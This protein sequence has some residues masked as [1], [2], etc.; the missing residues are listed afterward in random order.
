MTARRSKPPRAAGSLLL[1]AA[2]WGCGG[3]AGASANEA[4][5]QVPLACAPPSPA[6][7][8]VFD[9]RD[10]AYGAKGD[11]V[12]DDTA[13]L[14]KAVDA[15]KGTGGTVRV[16]P[17]TYLVNAIAA[18]NRGIL[19]GSDMTFAMDSGAV[20]K[21]IPNAASNYAILQISGGARVNIVG[22]TLEGDRSAH[23][24]TTGEWGH[25]LVVQGQAQ[26][27]TVVGVTARE[28][29]GDGFYVSGA[30]QV[31]LCGVT[32]DHNRRQG[33]SIT[34]VDGMV[35]RNSLFARTGGTLPEA[36]ID[37]EPNAG[38]TVNH[39]LITGC[40]FTSNAGDGIAD[41]VPIANTGSAFAL[42][43]TVDACTFEGN[44][45]NTLSSGARSGIEV[46]NVSGHALTRNL[47]RHTVGNGILLRNGVTA[48]SVTGNT[49]T[50]NTQHGI[51]EYLSS[52][53]TISGNTVSGN[54]LTP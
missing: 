8:L 42:D 2:L 1:L 47:I 40:S 37:I 48:T 50:D 3:G 22:G 29:W 53:N 6:S 26:Q 20:L 45:V 27:V 25:G 41:G 54:G 43:V 23:L 33:L 39:L 10:A 13:A 52:G 49:V 46:S 18:S 7:S 21:A 28:C 32:A 31:T 15:A 34:A 38:Q 5:A 44:G 16:P 35:V 12:T 4:A 30:S 14:Q 9:V 24:G 51:V 11:G 36:G 19:L 17:G